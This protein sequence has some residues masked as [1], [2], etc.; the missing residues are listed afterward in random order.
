MAEKQH[1]PPTWA[2]GEAQTTNQAGRQGDLGISSNRRREQ[3]L[4]R[5]HAV[6]ASDLFQ[7]RDRTRITCDQ[8]SGVFRPCACGS[9]LFVVI[10]GVGPHAAQL[11]C[12]ACGTGGRWLSRRHF[13]PEERDNSF[14][15]A[16]S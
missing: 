13:E 1:A 8:P 4:A 14:S 2:A 5:H 16:A 7:D 12:D 6:G 15:E 9:T 11:K 3:A 10:P